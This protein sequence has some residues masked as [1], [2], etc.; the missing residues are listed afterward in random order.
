MEDGKK[1]G[2]FIIMNF[3]GKVGWS[4][5]EINSYLKAW[6]KDRNPESLREVY[7]KGQMHSFKPGEKLP[8]NCA[9]ES[10]YQGLNICEPD[11]IC[12]RIKNPVNYTLFRWRMW[13]RQKEE[14]EK[15]EVKKK[16]KEERERK[17]ISMNQIN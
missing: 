12:K 5:E 3:L 7:I 16:A 1:R 8:P 2:V 6:N 17:N 13:L 9:N 10:Y 11:G 14:E 4:K 15:K